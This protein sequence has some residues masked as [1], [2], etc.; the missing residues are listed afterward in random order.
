VIKLK[1]FEFF[2]LVFR[3][4]YFVYFDFVVRDRPQVDRSVRRDRPYH[5]RPRY[6]CHAEV[7][8][9]EFGPEVKKKYGRVTIYPREV[10]ERGL[11]TG[12]V[13]RFSP[14]FEQWRNPD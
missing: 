5:Q 6:P 4:L 9:L 8:I 11:V 3:F 14:E 1:V 13:L 12:L 2:S 7:I 10:C